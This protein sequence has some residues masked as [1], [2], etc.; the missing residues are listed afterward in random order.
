[1]NLLL[2]YPILGVHFLLVF[3][4]FCAIA[5]KSIWPLALALLIIYWHH[6]PDAVSSF[7][8]GAVRA[9]CDGTVQHKHVEDGIL[10]ITIKNTAFNNH[11]I[12]PIVSNDV[13]HNPKN[14]F[15]ML[16]GE[17]TIRAPAE[18]Y[19]CIINEGDTVVAGQSNILVK[20]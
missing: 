16:G 8:G 9:P 15:G 20:N 18:R 10:V 13:K 4:F 1:M 6:Y 17:M 11:N 3:L 5:R 19:R 12:I 14:Y 7:G 2:D